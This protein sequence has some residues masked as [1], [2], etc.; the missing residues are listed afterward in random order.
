MPSS[1]E[2]RAQVHLAP[3]TTLEL[4][5]PAEFFREIESEDSLVASLAWARERGL[6]ITVLGGGSNAV[7]A[8]RGVAGLVVRVGMRGIERKNTATGER[9]S[10]AAGERWDVVVEQSVS[11]G[12]SGIE[13]LA[14]IPGRTGAAPVQN[15][16]AYGQELA[17]TFVSARAI[18]RETDEAITLSAA[19]CRFGYRTSLL[20]QEPANWIITRIELELRRD[21]LP[22]I[23]YPEL[24]EA[25]DARG[26]PTLASIRDAVLDLRRHKSMVLDP[27]DENRR[28]A[29]SFFLNPIVTGEAA[30]DIEEQARARRLLADSDRMPRFPAA[31][32]RAKIPAAW[33]IES[34]GFP[35]GERRGG[36]G[37][38]SRHALA[39]VH[40]G[41]STTNEL[42]AFATEIQA[43]V[44]GLF[45]VGLTPEPAL[46][47]FDAPPLA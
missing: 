37:L 40:H 42:I 10:I 8:D 6:P 7:V 35:K 5:G 29:G 18:H 32:N 1:S 14:G 41:G 9:W 21:T 20:K 2:I 12:L 45:G 25:I 22:K 44:A 46:L 47:G 17:E 11:A 13:C 19:D 4:G 36:I 38:S 33:L 34:A 15:I 3:L 24:E 27:D 16:G 39:L 23:R 26:T 31:G 43:T 28:T 30:D